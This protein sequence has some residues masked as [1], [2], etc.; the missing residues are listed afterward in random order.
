MRKLAPFTASL[1][2]VTAYALSHIPQPYTSGTTTSPIHT[3]RSVVEFLQHSTSSLQNAPSIPAAP[4]AHEPLPLRSF[5]LGSFVPRTFSL[6]HRQTPLIAFA[7]S[8]TPS[9]VEFPLGIVR[10]YDLL[11]P[12]HS[13]TSQRVPEIPSVLNAL[14]LHRDLLQLANP[15][16]ELRLLSLQTDELGL[17]HLR[18]QQ[19]YEGIPIWGADFYVHVRSDGTIALLNGRYIPTPAGAPTRPR[20]TT[21]EAIQKSLEHLQHLTIVEPLPQMFTQLRD[22]LSQATASLVLLP[23]PLSGAVYLCYEVQIIPNLIEHYTVLVDALD[24]SIRWHIRNTCSLRPTA[25]TA[26]HSV[27]TSYPL[28]SPI[29]MPGDF[30]NASGT[31]L[32]GVQRSFRVYRHDD[33]LHYMIWDLPS[34]DR[35]RSQLPT[36][37]KGG[38]ITLTANNRDIDPRNPQV[39]HI[40]SPS[41]TWTDPAAVS[42]HY[43]AYLCDTYYRNTHARNSI[44]GQGGTIISIIHA[45]Q[46]GRPMDNA[47]WNGGLKIMVYGDGDQSFTPLAGGLDVA[48]HEMTHG[49]TQHTANLVYQFQPGALNE[50]FSDIFAVMVDRDDFLLGEDIVR[51][52]TGAIALRD[53]ANPGNPRVLSR[54]PSHMNEYANLPIEQDNGGVHINSGIPNRAAYLII[55]ALGR[56]KAERIYY[57]ALTKYLTRTS[58]FIDCRRA[59]IRAAQELY[60]Q[61]EAQ[62]AAQAFDAVGIYDS[63][64]GGG[65]GN[66]VPPVQGGTW[67]IAFI[68]SDGR[69]ALLRT[70][71]GQSGIISPDNPSTKVLLSSEGFPLSQLSTARSGDR[72]YF[73]NQQGQLAF[74]D[75]TQQRFFVVSL[76]QLSNLRNVCISTDGRFASLLTAIIEPS[77]YITDGQQV[78]RLPLT[79]QVPDGGA[80][81]T[82]WLADAMSWTPNMRDPRLAFDAYNVLPL[83]TGDT[84]EYWNIYECRFAGPAIYE[85]V[86]PRPEEFSLGNIAYSNTD[87]DLVVF[88]YFSHQTGIYETVIANFQAGQAVALGTSQ[89]TYSG[90]PLLDVQRPTFS[91]DNRFL[92]MVSPST[93]LLLVADLQQGQVEALEVGQPVYHPR[94]FAIGA[95][96][97]ASAQEREDQIVVYVSAPNELFVRY[98]LPEAAP[99]GLEILDLLGRPCWTLQSSQWQPAGWH[100]L[101]LHR[102]SLAP[103][104]YAVQLR[105]GQH[106][107][108]RSFLWLR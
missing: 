98:Y 77:I 94:W 50:S 73:I 61:T 91:P 16:R 58:E 1:L 47:Y 104:L 90:Q 86:P 34:L 55:Q 87:P 42:A 60:G 36:K 93:G 74:A 12:Q 53:L 2:L 92:A 15:F 46:E 48:A 85:L 105:R 64:G 29:T 107:R 99:I 66:E 35:S 10:M 23:H 72:I 89:W 97:V 106:V 32:N 39:Y 82:I 52:E 103:G 14:T 102:P 67:Y 70:Q 17:S 51:R 59:V 96:G 84:L 56:E 80:V 100:E 8:G 88:N 3:I 76:P 31:D 63:G 71:D 83:R 9:W 65:S 41:T 5:N 27:P 25:H 79:P 33:N 38:A 54:Q 95:T 6:S 68:L 4:F 22:E 30:V 81:N 11:S 108:V 18:F 69:I 44:D 7:P 43:N 49:V 45:T 57:R 40:T 19:L 28:H 20:L 78:A 62:A 75:L 26:R 37:A 101:R 13:S 24:G 21:A